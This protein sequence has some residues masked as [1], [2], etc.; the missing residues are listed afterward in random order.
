MGVSSIAEVTS[1]TFINWV[2]PFL[3]G[4][5][6]PQ[7]IFSSLLILFSMAG[8]IHGIVNVD[9]VSKD[10]SW[11][12]F[13]HCYSLVLYMARLC[14]NQLFISGFSWK[15]NGNT[16]SYFKQ[17]QWDVKGSNSFLLRI[18]VCVL[19]HNFLVSW[20]EV[21]FIAVKKFIQLSHMVWYHIILEFHL[22]DFFVV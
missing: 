2:N 11:P 3:R 10:V 13:D 12:C 17:R 4:E 6:K 22:W 16:A 7:G 14:K 21:Y 5:I 20:P 18:L 19:K 15:I 8:D 9:K 1:L